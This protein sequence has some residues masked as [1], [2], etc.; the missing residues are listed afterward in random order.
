MRLGRTSEGGRITLSAEL[1]HYRRHLDRRTE[2]DKEEEVTT[3][4]SL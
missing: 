2:E 1:A 4:A 3:K